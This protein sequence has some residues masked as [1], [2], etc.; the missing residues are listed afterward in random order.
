MTPSDGWDGAQSCWQASRHVPVFFWRGQGDKTEAWRQQG[1]GLLTDHRARG[2]AG[3]NGDHYLCHSAMRDNNLPQVRCRDKKMNWSDQTSGT[4]PFITGGD[5]I[6]NMDMSDIRPLW[7]Y[8]RW[9]FVFEKQLQ[10]SAPFI[11]SG[12]V[13]DR[14]QAVQAAGSDWLWDDILLFPQSVS[15]SAH[16]NHKGLASGEN[17]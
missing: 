4:D 17:K 5:N 10:L 11:P 1:A 6:L 12:Q 14:Q 2:E 16:T 15:V 7:F 13:S 9:W 3:H 8:P